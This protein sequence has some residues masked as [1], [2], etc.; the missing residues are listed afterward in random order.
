MLTM[1]TRYAL[2]AMTELA[3][4]PGAPVVIAELAERG[5]IPRKFLE[6]ILRELKQPGLLRSHRGRGGGYKLNGNAEDITLATV[7]PALDETLTPAGCMS[8]GG[9]RR[10]EEC[11][12][13]GSCAVR[14]VLEELHSTVLK[15]LEGTTLAGLVSRNRQNQGAALRRA[16]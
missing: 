2:K 10:C 8:R 9:R 16:G 6:A 15:I 3:Q 11:E 14:S 1:K 7:I 5:D 13:Y 12:R 4:R